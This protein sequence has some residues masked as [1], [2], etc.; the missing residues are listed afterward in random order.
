M[1]VRIL[2]SASKFFVNSVGISNDGVA[3]NNI[4]RE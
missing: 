2:N 3:M 1:L 4:Y